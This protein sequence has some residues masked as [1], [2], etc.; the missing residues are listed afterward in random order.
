[1]TSNVRYSISIALFNNIELTK[2]CVDCIMKNT[3]DEPYEVLFF[4]NNSTD[5]TRE[6]LRKQSMPH[7]KVFLSDMNR[8]FGFAH[9]HNL[10]HASGDYFVVLNNDIFMYE[11]DFL[12]KLAAALER[13][14]KTALVGLTN[15]PCYLDGDGHGSVAGTGMPDYVEASCMLM[16]TA[17][18]KEGLFSP[19]ME[20]AYFEDSDLSLHWRQRGYSIAHVDMKYAHVGGQT[21]ALVDAGFLKATQERNQRIFIEKWGNYLAT[22]KF[23]GAVA[24]VFVSNGFG[25]ALNALPALHAIRKRYAASRITFYTTYPDLFRHEKCFDEIKAA[26]HPDDVRIAEGSCDRIIVLHDVDYQRRMPLWKSIAD[27]AHVTADPAVRLTLSPDEEVQSRE[28]RASLSADGRKLAVVNL[29]LERLE[30]EGRSLRPETAAQAVA[31]LKLQGYI[32]VEAGRNI[33]KIPAADH[34]FIDITDI[35]GLVALINAADIFVGI[36]SG[37]FHIAQ[38][39]GK[40][41]AIF[42]GATAPVSRIMDFSQTEPIVSDI[43][44][45]GCYHRSAHRTGYHTCPRG[46]IECMSIIPASFDAWLSNGISSSEWYLIKEFITAAQASGAPAVPVVRRRGFIARCDSLARRTLNRFPRLKQFLKEV[47]RAKYKRG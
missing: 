26:S 35:R 43:F 4:D 41:S 11:K 47:R 10:A 9:N 24:V 31:R 22:R 7:K 32:V 39:L 19:E 15:T 6:Y 25:D 34:S 17:L 28:Y 46:T 20:F 5:G 38:Y 18:A 8:G 16:R 44:C 12:K 30:W 45:I 27:K 36:D 33:P 23:T 13:D 40:R 1:M 14:P 2:Q 21:S 3:G 42:F 29:F 37:P